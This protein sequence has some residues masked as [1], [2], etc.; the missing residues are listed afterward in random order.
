MNDTM[1]FKNTLDRSLILFSYVRN[2]HILI[3]SKSEI[4]QVGLRQRKQTGF[5][6]YFFRIKNTTILSQD[7]V[8]PKA[9]MILVPSVKIF[10]IRK[11][12]GFRFSKFK[13]NS[14]FKFFFEPFDS[15]FVKHVLESC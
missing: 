3:A 9:L 7:G 15:I 1:L 8:I 10:S 12:I 5:Q 2:D 13:S 4:S 14:F 11:L 6:F